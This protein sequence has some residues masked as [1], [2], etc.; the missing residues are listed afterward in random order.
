MG[1]RNSSRRGVRGLFERA[2]SAARKV[3]PQMSGGPGGRNTGD[4]R[5]K[6]RKKDRTGTQGPSMAHFLALTR[7]EGLERAR[8]K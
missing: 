4:P 5:K 1:T 7:G 3:S 2:V 6:R 8:Q